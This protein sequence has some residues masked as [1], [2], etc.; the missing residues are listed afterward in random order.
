MRRTALLLLTVALA[1]AACGPEAGGDGRPR[2]VAGFA[3]LAEVAGAVGGDRVRVIDL[4]PPGAEP[5]DVE[6]SSRE[7]DAVDDADLVVYL[8]GGFQPALAEAARRARR[9]LDLLHADERRDPHIWLDPVRLS[10]AVGEVQRALAAADP[11]GAAGYGR[12]AGAFRAEL[13][14]LDAELRA[15]LATCRRRTIVTAHAAFRY[16]ARRYGLVQV[17]VTGVSPEAEPDPSRLADLADRVRREGLTTVFTEKLVSPR[18]AAALAREAG[19]AVAVLDPLEGRLPAGYAAAM[20]AN[21]A[22][23]RTALGCT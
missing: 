12:R 8:G 5:H 2:V 7:V 9:R 11:G 17:A 20:R 19:V 18:V 4:T 15:G 14:G 22:V 6:L 1:A 21:L 16:L 23:L 13:A 10:E 3:R